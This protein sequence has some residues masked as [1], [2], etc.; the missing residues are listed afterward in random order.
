MSWELVRT[1]KRGR[2]R[3]AGW[4]GDPMVS[5]NRSCLSFNWI[6]LDWIKANGGKDHV[7]FYMNKERKQIALKVPSNTNEWEESRKIYFAKNK[8]SGHILMKIQKEWPEHASMIGRSLLAKQE[9][10]W[11]VI[12]LGGQ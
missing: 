9:G 11:V 1:A 3:P 6:V 7:C 4:E 12:Q 5:I 8:L 10:E 2:H